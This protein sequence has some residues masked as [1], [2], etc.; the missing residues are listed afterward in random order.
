MLKAP[1]GG[2][3]DAGFTGK[4]M[5]ELGLAGSVGVY[6]GKAGRVCHIEGTAQAKAKGQISSS[7]ECWSWLALA[8]CES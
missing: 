7:L 1:G 3:C 5:L 2:K 4:E 8:D 6:Q